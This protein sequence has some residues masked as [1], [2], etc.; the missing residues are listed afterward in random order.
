VTIATLAVLAFYYLSIYSALNPNFRLLLS[1]RIGWLVITLLTMVIMTVVS[2]SGLRSYGLDGRSILRK[3]FQQPRWWRSWYPRALRRPGDVWSRLPPELR[4]FRLYC[5]ALQI[6]VFVIVM[7]LHLMLTL[8]RWPIGVLGPGVFP[9]VVLV[10]W[11]TVFGLSGLLLAERRRATKFV[12]AKVNVTAAEASVILMM[13]TWG[14]A[15][16]RR[17]PI[18]SLLG[19]RTHTPRRPSEAPGTGT[20]TAPERPTQL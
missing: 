19:A 1:I 15:T 16:W 13:S 20:P 2:A 11:A 8:A 7:P 3:A 12:R 17:A 5:G 4:R 14:V 10:L 18:S 9:V 6:Y